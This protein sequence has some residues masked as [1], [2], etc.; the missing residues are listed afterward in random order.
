[1]TQELAAVDLTVDELS[2]EGRDQAVFRV[3]SQRETSLRFV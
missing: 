3:V 1:M 2:L